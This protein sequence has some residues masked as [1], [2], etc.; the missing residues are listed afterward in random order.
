M[1]FLPHRWCA[2]GWRGHD[3][4]RRRRKRVGS[5]LP[6]PGAEKRSLRGWSY[7]D[8]G[9]WGWP[10]VGRASVGPRGGLVAGDD[11]CAAADRDRSGTVLVSPLSR[12]SEVGPSRHAC[13]GSVGVPR[14]STLASSALP[15][16][17]SCVVA[18]NDLDRFLDARAPAP[19]VAFQ[20]ASRRARRPLCAVFVNEAPASRSNQAFVHLSAS[21]SCRNCDATKGNDE[22]SSRCPTV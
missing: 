2:T 21:S 17:I 9:G 15:D 13:A 5:A 11:S 12:R 20:I 4:L 16:K 10:D 8:G 14:G 7:G 3:A 22:I 19:L 6:L 18:Q 1:P